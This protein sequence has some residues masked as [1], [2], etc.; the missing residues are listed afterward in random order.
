MNDPSEGLACESLDTLVDV[1]RRRSCANKLRSVLTLVGIVA[2]VASIIARDDR[3]LGG[4][5]DAWKRR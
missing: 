3:H 2:G 5:G 1:A 4:A